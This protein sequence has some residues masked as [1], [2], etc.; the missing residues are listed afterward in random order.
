MA[1]ARLTALVSVAMA[2]V[3]ATL[4]PDAPGTVSAGLVGW[5]AVLV[6]A[7]GLLFRNR[8]ALV[9]AA[10]A[11]VV[12]IAMVSV[13][14]GGVIP[15]LWAQVAALVL[16]VETAALS[17]DTGTHRVPVWRSLGQVLTSTVLASTVALTMESAVYGSAPSGFLLRLI[18]VAAVVVLVGWIVTKWGRAVGA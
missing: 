18:A 6:L 12:R 4:V 10:V 8:M 17:M 2:T 9:F 5:L 13:A 14:I 15:P 3:L 7:G 1:F 11:F 16:I